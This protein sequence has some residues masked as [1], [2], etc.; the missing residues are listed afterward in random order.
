MTKEKEILLSVDPREIR[1]AILQHKKLYDLSIERSLDRIVA[2]NIYKGR[3]T[4]I[5]KNI[6]SAFIDIGEESNG[7]VHISD[8]L[9][10]TQKLQELFDMDFSHHKAKSGEIS[11][12]MKVDQPV[13]VQ[14]VKEPMGSKGARLTSNLSIPGRYLV[15]LPGSPHRGV[16]R[17]I[18][19]GQARERLKKIISAFEMPAEVGLICRTASAIAT[20]DELIEEAH[21]LW[22][23]W[24]DIYDRFNRSKGP[25]CLYRESDAVKKAIITAFDTGIH[26]VII[27]DHKTYLDSLQIAKKYQ[28]E[29]NSEVKIEHYKE[30]TPLFER[31]GI[32]K[33]ID[34]A[35]RRKVWMPSG[36][37]LFFDKTE[38]M[39]TIDVN[40]GRSGS[41]S[42]EDVEEALVNINLEAA[43]EIARQLRLRNAGGLIICDFIDMRSRKNQRRVLERLKEAMRDDTAKCTLLGMS[44]FGLVEMTRQRQRESLAETLMTPCP[45]CQGQGQIK[46]H[47]TV[48]FEI[49]R[50]LRSIA[51]QQESSDLEIVVHPELYRYLRQGILEDV[52]DH[53]KELG[54]K[55][56]FNANDNT[57]L[58]QFAIFSLTNGKKLTA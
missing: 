34:K 45:Y 9:E 32:D 47:Q 27:D 3:V 21:E 25:T 42:T 6:Q 4:H 5:L 37:Y 51:Q 55:I 48:L 31:F 22:K 28:K 15:L 20:T 36:G 41:Q 14:V 56:E 29:G 46:N 1:Y 44:E 38:A 30:S 16:S 50:E 13:L 12:L 54:L 26:R 35:L 52:I 57:H 23:L 43:D 10:N 18:R 2:G 8:I 49:E 7:F 53:A 39:L 33:E 24:C 11:E 40:S 17:K 19:D 58:N